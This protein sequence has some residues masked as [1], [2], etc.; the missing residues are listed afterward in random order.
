MTDGVRGRK[1]MCMESSLEPASV[2]Y[3]CVKAVKREGE[4]VWCGGGRSHINML[5][6]LSKKV[7]YRDSTYTPF[8]DLS[9]HYLI[10]VG[11]K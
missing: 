3:S 9:L 2:L 5:K 7:W 1:Y 6:T 4:W 8:D 11:R 10:C